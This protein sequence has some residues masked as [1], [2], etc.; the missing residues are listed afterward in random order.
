[1]LNRPVVIEHLRLLG[2]TGLVLDTANPNLALLSAV[3]RLTDQVPGL[4]VV[5]DHLPGMPRPADADAQKMLDS[6]LTRLSERP[7]VYIKI[8][9]VL[10][11]VNGP[12]SRDVAAHRARLDLIVERFGIDR[13]IYGSDWPNSEPDASY[14]E[15]LG[16]VR[17]YFR[18]QSYEA[19]EKY[20][21]RNS[22]A[23]YRWTPR[24]PGQPKAQ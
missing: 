9:Q 21:W 14:D 4:R 19:A 15:V 22:L 6:L 20:F 1:A 7:Q 23:A 8:S 18:N 3:V 24:E 17:T 5:I 11:A 12:A 2:E 16:L 13:V 10:R